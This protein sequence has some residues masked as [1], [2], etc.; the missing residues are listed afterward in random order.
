[1]V[2]FVPVRPETIDNVTDAF[3]I[4]QLTE[5]HEQKLGPAFQ[6]LDPVIPLVPIDTFVKFIPGNEGHYL[7]ENKFSFGH[8]CF[9]CK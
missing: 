6:I 9:P 3:T 4:G 1:M 2:K 7:T 8:R 5:H